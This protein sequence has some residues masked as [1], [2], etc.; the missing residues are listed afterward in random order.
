MTSDN[1]MAT[2][3]GKPTVSDTARGANINPG[4]D[5]VCDIAIVGGG[6]AGA[7]LAIALAPL[8]YRITVIEA[9]AFKATDQPSYDDRTLA[10]SHSSCRILAGMGLWDA[11]AADATAIKKIFVSEHAGPGEVVLDAS[12]LNLDEFGC[13][14]E[15]RRFGAAVTQAMEQADNIK[16]LSPARVT[17]L[18]TETSITRLTLES[19][20]GPCNL[21]A[22]L[23][24]AADGANSFIRRHANIPASTKNY[25]QTA[26]ICNITP[27]QAHQG[28]AFEGLTP[29]GPFAM[30][31]HTGSRCGMVWTVASDRADA[32][33]A[34]DDEEF[35]AR[36]QQR[37]G[38]HLG[39]FLKAGKRSAY[40]LKLV[41]AQRDTSERLVVLGNAAHAIHP[42]GAQGFNLALRDVAVLAEVLADYDAGDPGSDDLLQ[43]YSKW[44]KQDQQ[45]T[46]ALSNAMASLFVRPSVLIA[47][48]RTAGFAALTLSPGLRRRTALQFMGYRNSRMPRLA[49]GE[50]LRQLWDK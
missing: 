33:L 9:V 1:T 31:P 24:V 25:G 2:D 23:V 6:L 17:D 30:L 18:N 50:P 11:L 19:E 16:V 8:G 10:L 44:R 41:K 21:S 20:S 12:E 37:F 13:V 14:V 7:S 5:L 3:K 43:R 32:V 49:L 48:L 36:A 42:V 38:N 22:R 29:T 46:I 26:I 45:S 15:A 35:L 27:A 47:G 28:R 34:L 39:A 4:A 40:P